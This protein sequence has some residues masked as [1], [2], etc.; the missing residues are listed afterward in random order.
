MTGLEWESTDEMAGIRLS[1]PLG[2]G[3]TC[4]EGMS[5]SSEDR[6]WA[7]SALSSA[8]LLV[9]AVLICGALGLDDQN[10]GITSVNG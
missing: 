1:R 4:P 6:V 5:F 10:A 9:A 8:G 3:V 7:D 2:F